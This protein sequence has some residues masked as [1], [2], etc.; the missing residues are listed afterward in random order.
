MENDLG[1]RDDNL[2]G[3]GVTDLRKI[4]VFE[5]QELENSGILNY[6]ETLPIS[7]SLKS[8][9]DGFLERKH[10]AKET[11]S[12]VDSLVEELCKISGKNLTHG[13]WLCDK[14][15]YV[16]NSYVKDMGEYDSFDDYKDNITIYC[17]G[18]KIDD[19]GQDGS[20]FAYT[21]DEFNNA[22]VAQLE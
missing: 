21:E 22:Y 4:M 13:L 19:V 15:E 12:L 10:T 16:Y 2:F 5:I 18:F 17:K 6:C 3:E 11:E 9:M 20:L 14:P 8:K 7:D 1:Y